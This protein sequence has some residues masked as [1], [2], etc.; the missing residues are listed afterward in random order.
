MK[1][2]LVKILTSAITATIALSVVTVSA[3]TDEKILYGSPVS[4]EVIDNAAKD[5]IMLINEEVALTNQYRT[6]D[7]IVSAVEKIEDGLYSITIGDSENGIVVLSQEVSVIDQNDL[8]F[9]TMEDIKVGMN[10]STV[11]D[12]NAP[13]TMS[14][15]PQTAGPVAFVIR[16]EG[17]YINT[18]VF[19]DE[20][21]S[22]DNYLQLNIKDTTVVTSI[23]DNKKA[24]TADDVKGKEAIVLYG[25]TTRSVPAQTTP[26][27]VI[28]LPQI[29]MPAIDGEITETEDSEIVEKMIPLRETAEAKGYKVTWVSNDK[30]VTVTKGDT[31]IEVSLD[32]NSIKV[33]G[34]ENRMF[35]KVALENNKFMIDEVINEFLK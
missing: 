34:V 12:I 21:I 8:S 2:T 16:Q 30:P 29:E 6:I 19:N 7:G 24:L 32:R 23:E 13:T 10:I 27:M 17:K 5:G 15:P 25:A 28:V 31:V 1:R 14:L 33:N 11:I 20:L 18:S 26:D 22:E 3:D 9:K 35:V 4:Q